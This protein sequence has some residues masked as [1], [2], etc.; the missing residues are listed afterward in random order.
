MDNLFQKP[1][2]RHIKELNVVPILDMMTTLI[3]FLLQ[4]TSFM[5]FTK[6]T[7]P[8]SSTST[9]TDPVRPP[10]L[11]PK[12]F[13]MAAEKAGSL[14]VQL[15]WAGESSGA[16]VE[17]VKFDKDADKIENAAAV[18]KSVDKL[19][20]EFR[21][22]YPAEQNFQLGATSSIPYQHIVSAMDGIQSAFAP[23]SEKAVRE[24]A[25]IVLVSYQDVNAEYSRSGEAVE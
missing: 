19:V 9:I 4:I 22:E 11:S 25:N 17:I 10:P 13:L 23:K 7:I 16:K 1:K 15:M 6:I 24:V 2:R 12:I 21:K 8:P 14:K 20:N 18:L 3:I 5:E